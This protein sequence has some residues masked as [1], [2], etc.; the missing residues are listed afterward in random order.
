[1]VAERV[2]EKENLVRVRREDSAEM[3]HD[4]RRLHGVALYR[5]TE[6]AFSEAGRVLIHVDTERAGEKLLNRRL[7]YAA[8]SRGRNNVQ[9][10][11]GE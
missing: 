3:N 6:R 5:E 7:A 4:P 10:Y 9:V 1:M 11:T 8:I 2:N